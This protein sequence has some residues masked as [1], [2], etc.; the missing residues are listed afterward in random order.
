MESKEDCWKVEEISLLLRTCSDFSWLRVNAKA[1]RVASH[2]PSLPLLCLSLCDLSSCFPCS[3]G[4]TYWI[5]RICQTLSCFRAF[6]FT[7]PSHIFTHWS[8]YFL[9]FLSSHLFRV[10]VQLSLSAGFPPTTYSKLP[11]L[12]PNPYPLTSCTVPSALLKSPPCLAFSIA[13]SRSKILDNLPFHFV[14]YIFPPWIYPL[15]IE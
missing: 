7:V 9:T 10:F 3:L 13:I 12:N 6:A 15:C 14:Y 5:P 8:P 11:S 4:F 1:L 2:A